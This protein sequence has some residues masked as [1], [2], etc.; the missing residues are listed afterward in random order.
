[1]SQMHLVRLLYLNSLN[2]GVRAIVK[3]LFGME[4]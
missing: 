2:F 1:M 3:R 4:M